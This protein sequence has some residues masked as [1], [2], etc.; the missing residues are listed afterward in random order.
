MQ[1]FQGRIKEGGIF[2]TGDDSLMGAA[3][4]QGR[5]DVE[6]ESSGINDPYPVQAQINVCVYLNIL[7][8]VKKNI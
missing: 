8:K 5:Q 7:Q 4:P 3:T 6:V 1:V 2:I